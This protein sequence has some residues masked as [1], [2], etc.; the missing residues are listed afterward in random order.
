[1]GRLD[2]V[3]LAAFLVAV[4]MLGANWVGVRF[5]NRELPPFFGAALRFAIASAVLFAVVAVRGI[6][7]PR[8]RALWG[9]A[10]FGVGQYFATF[11]LIYW[12]LVAVPAG[13][14][15]VIFATLPLWTL[16]LAAVVGYERLSVRSVVG[17]LVA[18]AG[19]GIVFS[20]EITG[21]VPVERAAAVLAAA[22][23]AAVTTVVVRAF[24]RTHPIAT[25]AVGTLVGVPILLVASLVA[26]ER[27]ALPQLTATWL[28]LGYLVLTT[29]VGFAILVWLIVRWSPSAAAYGAVLGPIVT[30]ILATILAGETFGPGFFVG[31][32]I[33]LLGT[34]VGAIAAAAGRPTS[35]PAASPA[36]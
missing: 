18:I 11:A 21:N 2:R 28:A 4:V 8:G 26:G 6:E 29:C 1:M 31:G 36:K 9:A 10:L 15:S 30:V 33:V 35:Q 32:V 14:T 27:W 25:N 19:L 12:A 24:P 20:S 3:T 5:S 13:M 16:F 17:A 34:Y 22:F 23:F 7:M